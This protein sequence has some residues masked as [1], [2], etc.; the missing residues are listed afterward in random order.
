MIKLPEG[1]NTKPAIDKFLKGKKL[2]FTPEAIGHNQKQKPVHYIKMGDF[3][4]TENFIIYA[5]SPGSLGPGNAY[6]TYQLML[7][8]CT[9]AD[10]ESDIKTKNEELLD[11][12]NKIDYMKENKIEDF[13]EEAYQVYKALEI[14][15][16]KGLDRHQASQMV[17]EIFMK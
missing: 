7:Q 16:K 3:S 2:I 17:R 14:I 1:V 13:D 5:K 6:N 8:S 11:I 15:D 12:Q 9:M 10:M 4:S